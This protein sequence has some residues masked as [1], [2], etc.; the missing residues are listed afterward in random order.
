M[1]FRVEEPCE[2]G[3]GHR[4]PLFAGLT[5]PV[6]LMH[7]NTDGGVIVHGFGA[8][9]ARPAREV[10]AGGV[11]AF[12]NDSL[13]MDAYPGDVASVACAGLHSPI[14]SVVDAGGEIISD[15]TLEP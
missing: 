14:N 5:V 4:Y 2:I 13:A 6:A 15:F 10:D 12:D 9:F 1:T 7:H 11:F 3:E 8:G